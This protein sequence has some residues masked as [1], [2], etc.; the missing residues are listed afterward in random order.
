MY[1]DI[2]EDDLITWT[3][4]I[5][6][7]RATVT[8]RRPQIKQYTT[9]KD[10]GGVTKP[11]GAAYN[12]DKVLNG[13][14]DGRFEELFFIRSANSFIKV[15]A[16]YILSKNFVGKFLIYYFKWVHQRQTSE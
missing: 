3:R 8:L 4:Q 15:K 10:G 9:S 1:K 2:S 12:F 11:T 5:I 7:Y 13:V 6:R 16:A 14:F